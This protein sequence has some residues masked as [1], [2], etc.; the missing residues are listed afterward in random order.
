MRKIY[1]GILKMVTQSKVK[2][3]IIAQIDL[4][5]IQ[6]SSQ[7]SIIIICLHADC[8]AKAQQC[9]EVLNL[10]DISLNAKKR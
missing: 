3:Y 10:S 6:V 1:A 4:P 7:F 9:N 8:P 5:N 2:Y